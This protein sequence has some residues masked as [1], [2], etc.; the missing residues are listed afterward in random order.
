MATASIPDRN[1]WERAED[2]VD[3]VT[4][5]FTCGVCDSTGSGIG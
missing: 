1:P 2:S 4:D 5:R 3:S